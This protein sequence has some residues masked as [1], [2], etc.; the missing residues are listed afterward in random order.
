MK[1]DV[2]F[3]GLPRKPERLWYSLCD[4]AQ[5]RSDGL[6]D[7][8]VF[9]TW[10]G[11]PTPE[12]IQWSKEYNFEII[13]SDYPEGDSGSAHLWYQMR[14]QELG[15]SVCNKNN[16]ILKTRTDAYCGKKILR[17]MFSNPEQFLAKQDSDKTFKYR[18]WVPW[19]EITCL[20]YIA[21]ECIYGHYDD[22]EKIIHYDRSYNVEWSPHV[23]RFIHNFRTE[24]PYL[25][26]Y[27]LQEDAYLE[28]CHKI[29]KLKPDERIENVLSKFSEDKTIQYMASYYLVIYK[30]FKIFC[31][32]E[33]RFKKYSRRWDH[34]SND[35]F[36]G[37][38][39]K[40]KFR[41]RMM[42]MCY[43]DVWIKNV[44]EGKMQQDQLL[45]NLQKY[46]QEIENKN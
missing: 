10:K 16:F 3:C 19:F 5:L 42:F 24:F 27:I 11:E 26:R 2:I 4:L 34:L 15:M 8:I 22:M 36:A 17:T 20:F 21:D 6:V 14:S 12:I 43:D 29:W 9:A 18:I 45:I 38:F 30:Y 35:F 31:T 41:W 44:V 46:I 33:M 28:Q 40:E 32:E 7:K 13:E 23:I 25:D 39:T 1:S 37:N